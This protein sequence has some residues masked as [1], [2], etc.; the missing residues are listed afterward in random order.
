V[1]PAGREAGLDVLFRLQVAARSTLGALALNCGGLLVDH[2]WVRVLGG[3]T[4]RL[5]DLATASGL[6]RPGSPGAP[7]PSLTVAFDV[8]GG[9]FA[10]NGGDLPGRPGEVCYWVRTPWPGCRPVPGTASWCSCSSPTA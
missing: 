7:P 10:V 6:G 8:L 9:R 1:L 3:G 2:G 5:P 4:S